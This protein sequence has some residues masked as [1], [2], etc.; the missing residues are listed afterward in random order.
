MQINYI[1]CSA[2]QETLKGNIWLNWRYHEVK[3]ERTKGLGTSYCP[4]THVVNM[5]IIPAAHP[6]Q[7]IE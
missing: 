2:Y 3:T 7:V 6:L 1:D 4:V 5:L